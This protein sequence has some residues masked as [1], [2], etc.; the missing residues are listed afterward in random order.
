MTFAC[1]DRIL[2]KVV[3]VGTGFDRTLCIISLGL[4]VVCSGRAVLGGNFVPVCGNR[5][6]LFPG[7]RRRV[8]PGASVGNLDTSVLF[9][10]AL[11]A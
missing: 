1:I 11:E 9:T 3:P 4:H 6:E 10:A 8:D 7:A 5:L 2:A